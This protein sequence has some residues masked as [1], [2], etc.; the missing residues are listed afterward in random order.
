MSD[1]ALREPVDVV[2]VGAGP[3]G[4]AAAIEVARAGC[5]VV[6]LEAADTVG[7]G[8]R[9]AE[10][11]RPG[12]VHDVCSAIHPLAAG[13]PFFRSVPLAEHG[14]ELVHPEIPLVH[15]LDGGRGG[16][17]HR[18]IERTVADAGPD[19]PAWERL[20]GPLVRRW[21]HVEE[22]LLG[23]VVRIPAHP[24]SMA[25][26][27]LQ[28]VRRAE[29]VAARFRTDEVRGL[30]AGIAAH[31]F[32]P[33]DH[34]LTASFG[35][36][37]GGLAHV[38]GWPIV[39]GGSQQL[40]DALASYL[41]VLGG[42]V[43]T[44]HRVTSLDELPPHRAVLAD[45]SPSQL[46]AIAGDRL[47]GRSRRRLTRFRHGP[48]ACKVDFALSGPV[49][50]AN[51]DARR[52]G[53]LHLG[54]TYE[55]IAAAEQA[56][57]AGQ[58][59]DHPFVLAA[60]PSIVDPSRAPEG[61]HTLWA[62]AHVP[63]GSDVDVSER[64][65]DQIERFAPGFRDLVL[66]RHVMTAADF[67][68]YNPTYVGGDISGG[69]HT[70]LQLVLRPWPAIDPYRTPVDG[71]FLCSASTPPGGGVHGMC[72]SRAARSALRWLGVDAA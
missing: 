3:N 11:T 12:Y 52:A 49:P 24:V 70:G 29:S 6:V 60:Q 31:A 37:L 2:V 8:T 27:G 55:Q 1:S 22:Q 5:S 15:P 39:R 65:T 44:G 45:L 56:V 47:D 61:H 63:N 64:I 28:A 20:Y 9:S 46:V 34:H 4:L 66:D 32:L 23:P 43:V 13:S 51:D 17:L 19:G 36:M 59:P 58:H 57:A 14:C 40:A 68:A 16:V 26:F 10:L 30:F 41:T 18:S 67:E 54:G 25:R 42:T 53:T 48:G 71:V 62:Y 38:H 7:G 33:L 50:W 72:G 35:L 21:D 69:A